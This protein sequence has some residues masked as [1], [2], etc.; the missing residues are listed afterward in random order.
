MLQSES[1]S[2]KWL[3][4]TQSRCVEQYESDVV[5]RIEVQGDNLSSILQERNP[6]QGACPNSGGR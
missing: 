5:T 1:R 6:S 4:D 3:R 2:A